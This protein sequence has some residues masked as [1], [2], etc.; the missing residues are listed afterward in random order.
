MKNDIHKNNFLGK[1]LSGDL[2]NE[3]LEAFKNTK[4]Y[5]AYKDIVRGVEKFDRPVFD[6]EKGLKDQKIYNASYKEGK[7]SKVIKLRIWLYS[8]AAIV[9]AIIG[10][11]TLFFQGTTIRTQ[12]AQTEVITLPDHSLV[13]LNTDSTL[14][15]NKG[16]FLKNRVLELKGEAFFEVQKGSSFT[17]KTK[18]GE[19]TVLGTE[20]DAY[21]RGQTLEVHCFEG[22][23]RVKKESSEV[24]LTQGKGAKSNG[25]ELLS[26][27]KIINPKPDWLNGKSSFYEVPLE[28]LI[29][30]LERQYAIKIHIG[31]VDVKRVFTGFF[32]HNNLEAALHTSF[33]PMKISYTF[34]KKGIIS[35]KNK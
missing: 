20:F 18:N 4:D 6:I 17:V 3:E 1:W 21:S 8:A 2:S 13:T 7:T 25:K 19:I 30:E 15:Y 34:E 12:I 9:L 35:L 32:K 10:I 23:V 16:S 33:D 28:R 24:I 14:K 5:L 22:K 31:N 27:F 29:G 11:K 26:I